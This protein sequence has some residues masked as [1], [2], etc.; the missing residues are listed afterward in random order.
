M[1]SREEVAS[2]RKGYKG[3]GTANRYRNDK[4]A[5]DLK[6]LGMTEDRAR[7]YGMRGTQ[8]DPQQET[9]RRVRMTQLEVFPIVTARPFEVEDAITSVLLFSSSSTAQGVTIVITLFA[10]GGWSLPFGM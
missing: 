4:G 6:E 7:R 1:V 8:R 2:K 10:E 5:E 9:E 3:S